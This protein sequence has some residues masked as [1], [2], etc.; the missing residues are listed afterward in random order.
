ME[1]L[2]WKLASAGA[3]AISAMGAGKVAEA[4]WKLVTGRDI[5]REDDDEVAL[6]SLI[7]FAAASAAIV[8]VAQRYAIRSAKK[9]YGPAP[10][11]LEA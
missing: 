5:P 6:V 4:G 10:K 9:W 8:A 3:M 7:L 1:D 2:G 11:K